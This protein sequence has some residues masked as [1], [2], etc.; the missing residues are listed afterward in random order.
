MAKKLQKIKS[1]NT[2]K[3]LLDRAF[4]DRKSIRNLLFLRF[5][6]EKNSRLSP[7]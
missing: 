1:C 6:K 3:K 2:L 7:F 4:D 5:F